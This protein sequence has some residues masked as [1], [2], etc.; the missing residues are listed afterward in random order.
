MTKTIK[1]IKS[2]D[3]F[4]LNKGPDGPYINEVC[5]SRNRKGLR[6][7]IIDSGEYPN[8]TEFLKFSDYESIVYKF[9]IL[10]LNK[11]GFSL[12]DNLGK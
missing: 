10:K 1:Q 2:G 3:V 4:T 8:R 5:L 9:T 12:A 7:L 6:V 11:S